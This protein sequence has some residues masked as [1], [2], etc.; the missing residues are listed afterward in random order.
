MF[1]I[2]FAGIIEECSKSKMCN[3]LFDF[4]PPVMLGVT[5]PFFAKT[6]QQW[7]HIIRVGEMPN[8]SKSLN[9]HSMFFYFLSFSVLTFPLRFG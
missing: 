1:A 8:L 3:I 6:L 9:M 2:S 5:N 7:P 4:R